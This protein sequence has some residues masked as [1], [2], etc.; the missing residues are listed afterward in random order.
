MELLFAISV[1][2]VIIGF[3]LC[4]TIG[5][6]SYL[7]NSFGLMGLLKTVGE[8]SPVLAFVPYLNSYYLGRVGSKDPNSFS[9]LGITFVIMQIVM[10]IFS[11]ILGFIISFVEERLLS[12][13]IMI[14]PAILIML[15]TIAYMVIYYII[16]SRIFLKYS[17][18]GIIFTLVNIFIG[19]GILAPILLFAI[20][21]NKPLDENQLQ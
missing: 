5:I 19:G 20:R 2:I 18:N 3:I 11:F 4:F 7:L 16:Y 14:I 1:G 15:V 17:K 13:E 21:N 9:K 10:G 12:E 8:K 6:G